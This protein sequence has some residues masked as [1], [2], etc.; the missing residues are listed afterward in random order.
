MQRKAKFE[1]QKMSVLAQ[2]YAANLGEYLVVSISVHLLFP[3][4]H[5]LKWNANDHFSN[6]FYMY[7]LAA[8]V[9]PK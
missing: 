7:T 2:C 1:L 4:K 8:K 3:T 6:V 5:Y 9:G